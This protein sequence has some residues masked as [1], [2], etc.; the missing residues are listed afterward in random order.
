[1]RRLQTGLHGG[2]AGHPQEWR[3]RSSCWR[4]WQGLFPG[5][6]E[7]LAP[8]SQ[9]WEGGRRPGTET[10]WFQTPPEPTPILLSGPPVLPGAWGL[11]ALGVWDPVGMEP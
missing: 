3:L 6:A 11:S 9:L 7:A 1:M 10:A 8:W 4:A 5:F 2:Y